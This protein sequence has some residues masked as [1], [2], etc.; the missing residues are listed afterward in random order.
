MIAVNLGH[1]AQLFDSETVYQQI[2][3]LFFTYCSNNVIQVANSAAMGLS[4]ILAKLEN[5]PEKVKLIVNTVKAQYLRSASFKKRQLFAMMCMKVMDNK[6]LFQHYFMPLFLGLCLDP[7]KNVRIV[8]ARVLERHFSNN[9]GAFVFDVLVN[10]AVKIL[11]KD[12]C[13]DVRSQLENISTFPLNDTSE[14][15]VDAWKKEVRQLESQLVDTDSEQSSSEHSNN[16][17]F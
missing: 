11:K 16:S 12:F 14:V 17:S 7:V 8:V 4:D 3:P 2:M 5:E 1:F 6:E 10:Q 9:E 15:D 13:F